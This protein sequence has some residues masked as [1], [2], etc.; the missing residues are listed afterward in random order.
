MNIVNR[1]K[2]YICGNIT[3]FTIRDGATLYRE[4]RCECCGASLRNSDIARQLV[5]QSTNEDKSI[6]EVIEKLA[7]Y[8]ILNVCSSGA[9][10]EKLK[11]LPGYIS[12]EYYD[13]V[14][15]GHI[16]N[17]VMC[18]D[19]MDI[20]LGESSLDYII[21]E[22][23]FEHVLNYKKAFSEVERV[24]KISGCHIFSVPVHEG[25]KTVSRENNSQKVYHG[26]PIREAGA[27][28]VTDFGNDLPRI[29]D[30]NNATNTRMICSH[31]FYEKR[32]ITDV[33]LSYDEY[34]TKMDKMDEYFKY[35]SVVFVTKKVKHRSDIINWFEK[36]YYKKNRPVAD[37]SLI[38]DYFSDIYKSGFNANKS[39]FIPDGCYD[40]EGEIGGKYTWASN[41]IELPIAVTDVTTSIVIK[42]Y[43]N[44][45]MY[46]YDSGKT[47]SLTICIN[48]KC[49]II[50]KLNYN[51]SALI[52]V[53]IDITDEMIGNIKLIITASD[54]KSPKVGAD[55]NDKRRLSWVLNS[56]EQIV[57]G[58]IIS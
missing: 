11:K 13:D 41:R 55:N 44:Y 24:L 33:D 1:E 35:N 57:D 34:L 58:K 23:V 9:L 52:D 3:D 29:I 8:R 18:V 50:K 12:S 42:G 31:K 54:K 40:I 6:D 21:S 48:D 2:C 53:C 43:V 26:D 20:P 15:N 47:F 37:E 25:K 49:N 39:D 28:V 27:L 30:K 32:D 51:S 46:E 56:I 10:H 17:G 5:I 36:N 22:D 38:E 4:A 19:L 7:G 14:P 16:K 45:D